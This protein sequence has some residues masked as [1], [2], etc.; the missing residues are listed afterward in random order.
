[1]V[2]DPVVLY[3]FLQRPVPEDSSKK[4]IYLKTVKV[5]QRNY[6][7]FLWVMEDIYTLGAG[8]RTDFN[9]PDSRNE[10]FERHHKLMPQNVIDIQILN[11]SDAFNFEVRFFDFPLHFTSL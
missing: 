2:L 11:V 7:K 1:M 6:S 10:Y 4:C 8:V 9:N 3:D 5:F